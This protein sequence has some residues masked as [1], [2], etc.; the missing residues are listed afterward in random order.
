MSIVTRR[1][2]A[3][4][5]STSKAPPPRVWADREAGAEDP[6]RPLDWGLVV[7]LYGYTRPHAWKRNVLLGLVIL[8]SVQLPLMAW[9]VGWIV[10]GPIAG[11]S[12]GRLAWGVLAFLLLAASTHLVYHFR[13]RLALELGEAV[14]HDLRAEIFAHLQRMQLG[15]FNDTK[16]GRIISRMTSDAEAVRAG[17]QEV[18]FTSLVGLGQMAV[19]AALMAAAD[20]ALFAFVAGMVPVLWG[21]NSYFRRRISRAYRDMQESFSRVTSSV[22]ESIG[23]IRVTQGS[24]RQEENSRIFR[25]LVFDHSRY[26]VEADRVTGTFLPLLDFNTQVFLTALLV[27]GGYR[28]LSPTATISLGELIQF[29]F[30][31]NIFF[32]PIQTLGDQY[33]QALS[34]MAGAERV[35]RLLCTAPAWQDPPHALRPATLHGTVRFED[36][37]F[38]YEPGHL[39]L[40]NIDFSAEPGQMVAFVGHTGS[41]KSSL[42]NLI[43][44]FYLPTTGRVLIDGHDLRDLDAS[45]LHRQMGIVFQQNFLFTGS[46][47]DNIRLGRPAATDAEVVDAVERLGC[48]DLLQSLP[49]GLHTEAGEGGARLSLGQRQ[50]VCFA[51]AMLA[52]PKLLLLDEATSSVDVLTEYRIQLALT[53]L[54]QGRTSFVVAHRLTTIRSA[55]L[56]LMLDHGRIIERGTH[57]QL[58]ALDGAYASLHR[59]F[60]RRRPPTA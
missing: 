57:A 18:L 27:A 54:L 1:R 33:H 14:V 12:P 47:M 42:V 2:I 30:L 59:P 7:W 36:V 22:A 17:V 58:M 8:R 45:W 32:Q 53:K 10:T 43:A 38:A 6:R 48:L 34:A 44:K 23:G 35:R 52:D 39:V 40:H 11:G 20:P 37:S 41:G 26:N 5:A 29:L 19:A 55:E 16:V 21:V 31:A 9:A 51:R 49:E 60:A 25:D 56:V 50:L 24:V 4:S 46:V 28:V 15:F 13:Q 3:D